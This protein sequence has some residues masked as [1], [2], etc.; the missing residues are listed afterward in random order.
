MAAGLANLIAQIAVV[1]FDQGLVEIDGG[2]LTPL[3]ALF[4]DW[5][6]RGIEREH[7]REPIADGVIRRG[8]GQ[9]RVDESAI[10]SGI[11]GAFGLRRLKERHLLNLRI[12]Q[13]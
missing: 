6:R 12:E 7:A 2:Q 8:A 9:R 1:F 10:R 4:E 11:G 5:R 3:A 13:Q